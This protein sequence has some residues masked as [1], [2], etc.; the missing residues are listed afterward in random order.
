MGLFSAY[1]NKRYGRA[2]IFTVGGTR[3]QIGAL[4]EPLR[5]YLHKAGGAV[6]GSIKEE[7]IAAY[8]L[9]D[10]NLRLPPVMASIEWAN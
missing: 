1:M 9:S 5:K 6:A 3:E 10:P 2:I 8:W 7:R 4:L